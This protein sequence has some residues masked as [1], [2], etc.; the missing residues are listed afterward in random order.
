MKKKDFLQSMNL[1]AMTEEQF[2][3]AIETGY[4]EMLEGRGRPA[5]VVF[6]RILGNG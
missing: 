3:A 5:N 1:S 6:D 2:N 4:N